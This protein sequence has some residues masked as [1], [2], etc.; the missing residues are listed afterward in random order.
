MNATLARKLRFSDAAYAINTTPKTLR[1]WLARG[2]VQIHTPNVEGGW[3]EYSF[4]DIAIL[5]L[6]RTF[7]KHGVDLLTANDLA[8]ITMQNSLPKLLHVENPDERLP[9]MWSNSRL[10]LYR[11][12]EGWHLEWSPNYAPLPEPAHAY[13]NINVE[14][15]FR[16][17]F[18]RAKE[19]ANEGGGAGD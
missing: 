1:N 6:V 18:E 10:R 19:S 17:A 3:N 7:V 4:I 15:I 16:E 12:E 13:I 2:L 5:A 14:A 8:N 11:S 9:L